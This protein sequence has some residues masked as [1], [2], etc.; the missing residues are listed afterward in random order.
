MKTISRSYAR[1]LVIMLS[2]ILMTAGIS[3]VIIHNMVYKTKKADLEELALNQQNIIKSIFHEIQDKEKTIEILQRYFMNNPSF[4]KTGEYLIAKHSNDSIKYLVKV[5]HPVFTG[6]SA[7]EFDSEL[8]EP[9]RFALKEQTGTIKGRDYRNESVLAYC[10]YLPEFEWGLVTKMDISEINIPLYREGLFTLIISLILIPIGIF[11]FRKEF[12]PVL[13]KITKS[14]IRYKNLFEHSPVPLWE[15]DAKGIKQYFNELRSLGITDLNSYVANIT[16]SKS[17]VSLIKIISVN[18]KSIVNTEGSGNEPELINIS[19]YLTPASFE[20]IK[21]VFIELDNGITQ[22]TSEI[23]FVISGE[24]KSYLAHISVIPGNE[25]DLSAILVSF[26]DIT[27]IKEYARLILENEA[28]LKRSQEIAHLGSWELD[29]NDNH[30]H[31]TDEVYRIF[32][33][34]REGSDTT[35]DDF[36]EAIHPEDRDMVDGAYQKSIHDNLCQ[37]DVEHRIIRKNT[38]EVR[39]VHEKCEHFRNESGQII[40]SIGMVHDITDRKRIENELL[41]SKQKL[42]LALENGKIGVWEW[43][44]KTD[45]LTLDKRI[46]KIFELKNGSYTSTYSA[47]ENMVHEDDLTHLRKTIQKSL[48]NNSSLETIFRIKTKSG[49][50]KYISARALVARERAGKSARL[51]GVAFD[52]TEMQQGT[53]KLVSKLNEELLRSNKELERFA[54]VA[55]HDLQEPLRMVTNFTQLLSKQYGDKLDANAKEYIYYAV[56]GAKRMYDLI[57]GL[58]DYSRI[59]TKGKEF[60]LVDLNTILKDTIEN[61]SLIIEERKTEIK[62]DNLPTVLADESQMVQLF[63]NLIANS[64]KFSRETPMITISSKSEKNHHKISFSDR[65]IGIDPQ[66]FERIFQIFQRLHHRNEFQ[67]TG[68][69]LA[70]CKRIVERHGG[71]IWVESE[72]G[73]GST[74]H[75][76]IPQI[77]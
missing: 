49:N 26:V 76:T 11:L 46:E 51:S 64:I 5:R 27:Q 29:I 67:G 39:F 53:E 40:R 47:L 73:K 68:I 2:M 63:Q 9:M 10:T 45:K 42:K 61:L 12:T 34:D 57:N 71:N 70:I 74:F 55:S 30:L 1:L 35:Y 59:H 56:D 24:T 72:P 23:D 75:F 4:G 18:Q 41:E 50:I 7:V 16:D 13:D 66:Y 54:Y 77:S 65:G 37:Y 33:L 14:Q 58:L 28:R 44:R 36:L 43:N 38:G 8:D 60:K 3:L 21:K 52:I 25:K 20:V 31:W 48:K 62:S 22:T 15:I 32:G 6:F 17:L 19:D 69:G